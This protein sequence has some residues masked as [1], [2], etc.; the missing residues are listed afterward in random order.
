MIP[1]SRFRDFSTWTCLPLFAAMSFAAVSLATAARAETAAVKPKAK[2][3]L[4]HTQSTAS[5][6]GLSAVS[7]KVVWAGG[8]EGTVL[9]T[10][11]GGVTWS[12]HPVPGA[13]ELQFR[14]IEAFDDQRAVLMTAGT[15]ARIYTTDDG[16]TTF[17]L[18]HE[19]PH[20]GAFFDGMAFWDARR[21]VIMSDPVD[22]HLLVLTTDDGGKGWQRVDVAGLP[23]AIDGEAGFA[24]SGTN[25]AVAHRKRAWIATGG[26]V[27]RVFSSEDG[28]RTWQATPT[29]MRSGAPSSGI[30]SIAFRDDLHGVAVGGDYQ[31]PENT[32]ANVTRTEDGGKTWKTIAGT[33][34]SGH[35]ACVVHLPAHG[36]ASWL[37][38]GR[39]GT[40]LS[41]DDGESWSRLSDTGFYAA[42]VADDGSVWAAGDQGRVARLLWEKER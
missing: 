23:P 40:D 22:G 34:P 16:G 42:S 5:L 28:G 27:A 18:A 29:P 25:V 8:S 4:T 6:R 9:R 19:S 2:W 17:S 14:D 32:R 36:T 39:A 21:G 11:D 12:K 7:A 24:A 33:P 3:Q 30:F 37:A 26:A 1:R 31:D 38:V 41:S 13:E 35:R 20:A 10:V 15:P